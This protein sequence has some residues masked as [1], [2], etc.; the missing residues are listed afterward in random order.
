MA[1][2]AGELHEAEAWARTGV[3]A[4]PDDPA[5]QAQLGVVL[6]DLG[7]FD[8]A[9]DRLRTAVR[10]DP[11]ALQRVRW[12][13][14]VSAAAGRTDAAARVL[15]Q[16]LETDRSAATTL[17]AAQV[18]HSIG[19]QDR[20]V[21]T[22]QRCLD[23]GAD[24]LGVIATLVDL[25]VD[26][27]P[28][29][30]EAVAR[31]G[32]EAHAAD[33]R[34]WL[35]LAR[36]ELAQPDPDS[37]RHAIDRG[38]ADGVAS[39]VDTLVGLSEA[40]AELREFDDATRLLIDRCRAPGTTVADRRQLIEALWAAESL[41]SAT[42]EAE[43]LARDTGAA[44][45]LVRFADYLRKDKRH[46]AARR[47]LEDARRLDPGLPTIP[48]TIGAIDEALHR[49]DA[50][51]RHFTEALALSPSRVPWRLKLME[52]Q[53]RRD[54][55]A[56]ASATAGWFSDDLVLLDPTVRDR[57]RRLRLRLG[58]RD[59]GRQLL[60]HETTTPR[61]AL[62]AFRDLLDGGLHDDARAYLEDRLT[63]ILAADRGE[64]P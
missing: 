37:A 17:A 35:A 60:D 5:L 30:A 3:T 53:M 19:M 63:A 32:V 39:D 50:A 41:A 31:R 38:L 8:E 1:V 47:V 2:S 25:L 7:R 54:D 26:D 22:L 13:A 55:L 23:D 18:Y 29:R 61:A 4:H 43:R 48:A 59:G 16:M 45:D 36:A 64:T 14:S 57:V 6:A 42:A 24:D 28:T 49:F 27:D 11:S 51:E 20:A 44:A 40:L 52:L 33:G 46:E 15:E 9:F 58:Q 21:A 56:A 10:L 34:A 62:L 12:L